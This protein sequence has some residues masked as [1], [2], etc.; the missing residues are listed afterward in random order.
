[1]AGWLAGVAAVG[2]L[3]AGAWALARA[4]WTELPDP[5]AIHWGASGEA[6]GTAGLD[7]TVRVT[8]GL[9]LAG[10]MIMLGLGA[11]LLPR[12]RLLRGWM[13]GIAAVV[14][15]AP[16]SLLLTLLPNRGVST[17]QEARIASWEILLAIVLPGLAAG[18]AWF[19][20]A[21][22][23]RASAVGPRIADG[24]P[25]AISQETYAERQV[26]R[27]GLWL[28]GGTLV[29][30]TVLAVPFGAA[31]LLVGAPLA[32]LIGW[33][34]VYSY[35]VDDAGLT[36]TVGPAG[37]LR[38]A[39]PVTEIEGAALADLAAREWGGWGYRTNGRDWAVVLRSGP[40]VR[41]ALAGGRSL[42]LT[43]DDP[44]GLAGRVNAAVSRHWGGR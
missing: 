13:T 15:V 18:A 24:A 11:A 14:A 7:G 6:N 34:S 42:S 27:V 25:V 35:R 36:L 38:W 12:P 21:R 31:L 10:L 28:S 43:S 19:T 8:T 30:M 4:W 32:W 23:P 16:A 41:V 40:G 1:M 29:L 33:L 20:A 2:V 37:P 22:P 39:V 3:V 26:M 5:V 17:W 9:G 44:P